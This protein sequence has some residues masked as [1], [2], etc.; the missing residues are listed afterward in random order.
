MSLSLS[1]DYGILAKQ[2]LGNG[3]VNSI[4]LSS[5]LDKIVDAINYISATVKENIAVHS[6][7]EQFPQNESNNINL[8]VL[9]PDKSDFYVYKELLSSDGAFLENLNQVADGIQLKVRTLDGSAIKTVYTAGNKIFAGSGSNKGIFYSTDNGETFYQSSLKDKNVN[10]ITNFYNKYFAGTDDNIYQSIDGITWEKVKFSNSSTSY[11]KVDFS[12]R[13]VY[14]IAQIKYGNRKILIVAREDGVYVGTN[15]YGIKQV[16]SGGRAFS[17]STSASNVYFSVGG[18]L[19]KVAIKDLYNFITADVVLPIIKENECE[20]GQEIFDTLIKDNYIYA[21]V[22]YIDIVD[23]RE[24]TKFGI[25]RV[26]LVNLHNN[27][28][29]KLND[30]NDRE[31]SYLKTNGYAL[32]SANNADGL[33]TFYGLIESEIQIDPDNPLVTTLSAKYFSYTLP[34]NLDTVYDFEFID[35]YTIIFGTSSGIAILSQTASYV[36]DKIITESE[37]TLNKKE[38]CSY[39]D[40]NDQ[41]VLLSSKKYSDEQNKTLSDRLSYNISQISVGILESNLSEYEQISTFNQEYVCLGDYTYNNDNNKTSRNVA[42]GFDVKTLNESIGVGKNI[43]TYNSIGIGSDIISKG[44]RGIAIGYQLSVSENDTIAIGTSSIANKTDSIAIGRNV[45]ADEYTTIVAASRGSRD[46]DNNQFEQIALELRANRGVNNNSSSKAYI[47][48]TTYNGATDNV[49]RNE[50]EFKGHKHEISAI[51]DLEDQLISIQHA[52]N[53]NTSNIENI[54]NS[55]NINSDNIRN[56]ENNILN[57]VEQLTTNI[58]NVNATVIEVSSTVDNQK[59]TEA[60]ELNNY[61]SN[62]LSTNTV[63]FPTAAAITKWTDGRY[64]KTSGFDNPDDAV[65]LLNSMLVPTNLSIYCDSELGKDDYDGT[66]DRPFK[67]LTKA[68]LQANIQR[69][70]AGSQIF[71]FLHGVFDVRNE[72]AIYKNEETLSNVT[73]NFNNTYGLQIYHPDMHAPS[74]MRILRWNDSERFTSVNNDYQN[75]YEYNYNYAKIQCNLNNTEKW[76][77]AIP[78]Y[79]DT[80]FE[81]IE[82]DSCIS[83]SIFD[84]SVLSTYINDTRLSDVAAEYQ[85]DAGSDDTRGL[86][87]IKYSKY[88]EVYKDGIANESFL[89]ARKT[90]NILDFYNCSCYNFMTAFNNATNISSCYFENGLIGIETNNYNKTEI[91]G[92]SAKNVKDIISTQLGGIITY[93]NADNLNQT[94][95]LDNVCSFAKGTKT[96]YNIL[97]DSFHQYVGYWNSD[98]LQLLNNLNDKSVNRIIDTH[99]IYKFGREYNQQLA[100]HQS[101]DF[102]D[103]V[104]N[105]IF[106]TSPVGNDLSTKYSNYSNKYGGILNFMCG[107][108]QTSSIIYREMDESEPGYYEGRCICYFPY[109]EQLFNIF[110]IEDWSITLSNIVAET[111]YEKT[112][113]SQLYSNMVNLGSDNKIQSINYNN[114]TISA[115]KDLFDG[116]Y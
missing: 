114:F 67:T 40:N 92:L 58:N 110:N 46:N 69:F 74:Y 20:L 66:K 63:N 93:T 83:T 4:S 38:I 87:D 15:T 50:I 105:F 73:T 112:Y 111:E 84:S 12:N 33:Q 24:I 57:N 77:I 13:A 100:V 99:L 6:V 23:L 55:V 21:A 103:F 19:Y 68:I 53:A 17:I 7:N 91:H 80:I 104:Y 32:Y 3:Y 41:F 36:R 37:L 61:L 102:I 52:I 9:R 71:I 82:F 86:L 45:S 116:I 43:S 28:F 94:I 48:T 79:C 47:T 1:V 108:Y 60:T 31:F 34:R 42:I 5:N 25:I 44:N 76:Q 70:V 59:V 11:V 35:S 97:M 107:D 62:S 64:L 51:S 81:N 14:D 75:I 29:T 113:S 8:N 30:I 98:T 39:I 65:N 78:V 10:I 106:N 22:S 85:S 115:Y 95:Y 49:N 72:A 96:G 89:I 88:P 26:N 54:N 56:L 109:L 16:K 27:E 18:T 2:N 90:C 101:I